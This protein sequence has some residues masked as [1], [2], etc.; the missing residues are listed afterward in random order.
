MKLAF[1]FL[2]VLTLL[3]AQDATARGGGGG[4]HG[5]G[6]FGGGRFDD[7]ARGDFGRET[8][9]APDDDIDKGYDPGRG[10]ADAQRDQV[11]PAHVWNAPLASDGG[12][13]KIASPP[14]AG[15]AG[16]YITPGHNTYNITHNQI[17]NTAN[18][19]RQNFNWNHMFTPNWWHN[20][21]WAWWNP[22]WN[23]RWAW[24]VTAWPDLASWWGVA[25]NDYPGDYDYGDNIYYQGDTIYYGSQPIESA[26][27]YYQQAQ[28]LAQSATDT[29]TASANSSASANS[30]AEPNEIDWK[31]MGVFSLVQQN[32]KDT[33]TVFQLA[34]NKTGQIK[35]NCYS[36]LT[37]EVKPVTGAV[38]KKNMRACWTV[39]SNKDVVYD[40]GVKNLLQKQGA[41]LVH[42][43]QNHT[44]QWLLVRLQEGSS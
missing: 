15:N 17:N 43:D 8:D 4:F 33:T 40:T 20:H 14:G 22:R 26:D 11:E 41:I 24:G 10:D 6:D 3:I 34:V 16:K 27:A 30:Q 39:G 13:G 28:L 9:R 37:N 36:V 25:S 42:L 7:F 35:G 23:D 19:V 31:P 29:N 18:F 44:E 1:F 2:V 5:G 32:Q 38:N 12:F 21:P